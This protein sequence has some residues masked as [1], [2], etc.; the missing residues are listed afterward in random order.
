MS[1]ELVRYE[2]REDVALLNF[3]D[4]KAN[5][6]SHASIPAMTAALER[7]E[8]EA[9]AVVLVGR[10]GRFSAGFDLSVMTQGGDAVGK[11]VCA[12]AEL[13]MRF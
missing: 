5:V 1:D 4:G 11:L 13:A 10:P 9:K 2:L 7:A 8:K 12:G 6:F 3:D